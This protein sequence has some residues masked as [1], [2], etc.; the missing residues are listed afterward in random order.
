MAD[1]AEREAQLQ[2]LSEIA[3]ELSDIAWFT[4]YISL[5]RRLSLDN[6]VKTITDVVNRE[7]TGR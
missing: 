1:Q 6:V 4:N 2:R 3:K 7:R 5:S